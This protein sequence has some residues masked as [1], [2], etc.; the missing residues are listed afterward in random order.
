MYRLDIEAGGEG[1]GKVG[2]C[3]YLGQRYEMAGT[4]TMMASTTC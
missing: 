4:Y 1:A 2:V 3:F